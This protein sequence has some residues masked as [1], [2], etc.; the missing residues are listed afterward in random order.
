MAVWRDRRA[1]VRFPPPWSVEDLAELL[2]RALRKTAGL[3][4]IFINGKTENSPHA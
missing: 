3:N 2:H 4:L 1:S